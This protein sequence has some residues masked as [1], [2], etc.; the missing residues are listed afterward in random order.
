MILLILNIFLVMEINTAVSGQVICYH[1]PKYINKNETKQAKHCSEDEM[2]LGQWNLFESIEQPSYLNCPNTYKNLVDSP[3]AH[4]ATYS[5]N[6]IHHAC[7]T[8]ESNCQIMPLEHSVKE[9]AKRLSGRKMLFVGDSLGGQQFV[10]ASCS[11]E[12]IFWYNAIYTEL[13]MHTTLVQDMLCSSNCS[14]PIFLASQLGKFP[15]ACAEC[16]N[17]IRSDQHPVFSKI[18]DLDDRQYGILV[19]NTG[20]WFLN[21]WG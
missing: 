7:F 13:V 2:F 16:P 9:V 1:H 19:L 18:K 11:I 3:K 8:T 17:G 5:K 21:C 14:N 12:N 20:A 4:A 6:T 10:E 15:S